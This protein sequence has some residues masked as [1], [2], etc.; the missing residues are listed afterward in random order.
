MWLIKLVLVLAL[1]T[2]LLPPVVRAQEQGTT[3]PEPN[4]EFFSGTISQMPPGQI[5]VARTVLGKP[6]ENRN[7][8]INGET[9][10]EGK[11]R[12]KARVTVGFKSTPDGDLAVRIIVRPQDKK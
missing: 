6:P 9:K 5:A 10:V 7:F 1:G 11:L 4:Y 12:L 2:P 8:I 3:P